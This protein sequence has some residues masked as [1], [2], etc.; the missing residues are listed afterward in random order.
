MLEGLLG[1]PEMS[2]RDELVGVGE[3]VAGKVGPQMADT[4]TGLMIRVK[5]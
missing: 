1:L 3:V 4:Y 5:S 2:L